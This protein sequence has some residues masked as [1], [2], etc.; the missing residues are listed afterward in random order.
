[1]GTKKINKDF[2]LLVKIYE[3]RKQYNS[4]EYK[5]CFEELFDEY[6]ELYYDFVSSDFNDDNINK[7]DCIKEYVNSLI[8]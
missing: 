4:N 1:M 2:F 5:S 8:D 7:I 3:S 6:V